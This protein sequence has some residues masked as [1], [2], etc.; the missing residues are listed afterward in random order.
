MC[1]FLKNKGI[2]AAQRF[3]RPALR[4]LSPTLQQAALQH[5]LSVSLRRAASGHARAA[6]PALSAP[7][8][9]HCLR[10]RGGCGLASFGV[11]AAS[12][13]RAP[14][15]CPLCRVRGRGRHCGGEGRLVSRGCRCP[16]RI[17][18]VSLSRPPPPPRPLCWG[19]PEPRWQLCRCCCVL[20]GCVWRGWGGGHCLH[21]SWVLLVL[22]HSNPPTVRSTDLW[23]SLASW[24]VR[25]RSLR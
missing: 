2:G 7:A 16:C 14:G 20:G 25:Q 17:R 8:C 22:C 23:I 19:R 18:I 15:C 12:P 21:C 24:C 5:R 10:S 9:R 4:G 11:C 13:L 3:N 1:F 6:E